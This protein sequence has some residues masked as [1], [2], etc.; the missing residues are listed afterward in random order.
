MQPVAEQK[1][2]ASTPILDRLMPLPP[3]AS[4]LRRGDAIP[5]G[6]C[7]AVGVTLVLW[8][9]PFLVEAMRRLLGV[10]AGLSP[11]LSPVPRVV[12][13]AVA[14][15][16][17]FVVSVTIHELGHVLAGLAA[18]FRY[19]SIVVGPLR[20][21]RDFRISLHGFPQAWRAGWADLYPTR[22][23]QAQVRGIAMVLAGP[24]ANFV[25][26]SIALLPL[27]SFAPYARVFA[28]VSVVEGLLDLIP[29]RSP[30]GP[31]DGWVILKLMRD[32]A[33]GERWLALMKL[34]AESRQGVMPEAYSADMLAKAVAYRDDSEDTVF[35][36]AFAYSS[37]FHQ[38]KDA[39]AAAAL[40]TCLEH[41]GRASAGLRL[42]LISDAAV[43]QGRRRKH[44][45]V[46]ERWLGDLPNLPGTQWL[47]LRAEA[48]ICDGQGDVTGAL[49][50]LEACEKIIRGMPSPTREALMRPL[51][52]WRRELIE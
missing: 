25:T 34:R 50:K 46:A 19:E 23:D 36:Y 16:A 38:H 35:S 21:D 2:P 20:L 3:P 9:P 24:A 51:E 45:D 1:N 5:I 43:F 41:S 28:V 27:F 7:L 31:S 12:V 33:W 52:R 13:I 32:R 44:R 47:R 8:R 18:G 4:F 10:F 42:A 14:L 48:A 37:A 29:Y 26:A 22:T 39:E 30:S 49:A 15:L 11:G 17:S 6:I 40:E